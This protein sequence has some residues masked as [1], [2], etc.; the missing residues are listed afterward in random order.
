MRLL[1][2]LDETDASDDALDYALDIAA[3]LDASLLFTHVVESPAHVTEEESTGGADETAEGERTQFVRGAMEDARATGDQLLR[4]AARRAKSL[5]I[6]ADTRIVDGDPLEELPTLARETS[7]D[8][9]IVGHRGV[10]DYSETVASVAKEL[11]GRSPVP[12]TVV[13]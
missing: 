11:I 4:E 6:S 8:G 7:V 3:R 2:A 1:V 13:P 10:D 12:V 9:V 5:G